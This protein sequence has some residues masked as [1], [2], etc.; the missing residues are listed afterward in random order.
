MRDRNAIGELGL[1]RDTFDVEYVDDKP[2]WIP[3]HGQRLLKER[4]G[5]YDFYCQMEDDLIIHD[6]SFF[7]KLAWFQQSFG[8]KALLA[9]VRFEMSSTGTPAKVIIDPTLPES[10]AAPFRRAG[11]REEIEGV[12][13]GATRCS[14]CRAIRTL[15]RSF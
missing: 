11:Q 10:M 5:A 1:V 3:F 13:T 9:P 6:P 2:P 14:I 12:W 4:L 7:A 15:L 8:F